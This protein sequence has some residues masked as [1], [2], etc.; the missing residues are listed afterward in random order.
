MRQ[1]AQMVLHYRFLLGSVGVFIVTTGEGAYFLERT[2]V[3]N[4]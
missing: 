1:N 4:E 2:D 3:T